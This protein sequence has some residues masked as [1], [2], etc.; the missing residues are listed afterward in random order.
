MALLNRLRPKVAAAILLLAALATQS[1]AQPAP[2]ARLDELEAVF[3]F[4]FAIFVNWPDTP[5]RDSRAPFII[6]VLGTDPFGPVLDQIV[7][8]EKL[9]S[10]PY[11][12]RRY[13]SLQDVGPCDILFI[14]NSEHGNLATILRF[15]RNRSI[16]TVGDTDD[17]NEL[18]GIIRFVR[19]DGRLRLRI[20]LAA[21]RA[22]RLRL[23]SK[24]LRP[25][26]IYHGKAR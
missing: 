8:G 25:A 21:A 22:A 26:E 10:R 6:G 2:T 11:L 7:A 23:S 15:L 18:G 24:L 12:V 19:E 20:N 1:A 5:P 16:L 17:F 9:G 3:L 13:P 14:S 4:N